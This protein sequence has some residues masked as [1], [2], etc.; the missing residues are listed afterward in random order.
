MKSFWSMTITP[1]RICFFVLCDGINFINSDLWYDFDSGSEGQSLYAAHVMDDVINVYIANS[2][3]SGSSGNSVCGFAYYPWSSSDRI[4]LDKDCASNGST[5][6]HELG[7]YFGLFHTHSQAGQGAE[8]VDGSNCDVAGDYLCDTPADPQLGSGNV[9]SNCIY[10]GNERD[11]NGDLYEPDPKNVMSYSRKSC[12]DYF[13]PEQYARIAYYNEADRNY[14]RCGA[15]L[16]KRFGVF[17]VD[18]STVRATLQ[19][20]ND[21]NLPVEETFYISYF[22]RS[23]DTT[24]LSNDILIGQDT[25]PGLDVSDLI[26]TTFS[27]DVLEVDSCLELGSYH[28]GFIVD[29]INDIEEITEADNEDFSGSPVLE[30]KV[31]SC[32]PADL[33]SI[34]ALDTI[35]AIAGL[36]FSETFNFQNIGQGWADSSDFAVYLS[37]DDELDNDDLSLL[38]SYLEPVESGDTVSYFA[39]V[40][41]PDNAEGIFYLIACANGEMRFGEASLL[42]N[43]AIAVLKVEQPYIDLDLAA[44]DG[45]VTPTF[46]LQMLDLN[47]RLYNQGNVQADS[48]VIRS[49]VMDENSQVYVLLEDLVLDI[50]DSLDFASVFEWPDV[51][52]GDYDMAVCATY[53]GDFNAPSP[54]ICLEYDLELSN[55]FIVTRSVDIDAQSGMFSQSDTLKMDLKVENLGSYQSPSAEMTVMLSTDP[56]PS[57]DDQLLWSDQTTSLLS[58][59]AYDTQLSVPLETIDE[60]S[61]YV[62]SCIDLD[63]IVMETNEMNNCDAWEIT[64]EASTSIDPQIASA[65]EI[66]PNPVKQLL[67]ISIDHPGFSTLNIRS[68]DGRLLHVQQIE[69]EGLYNIDMKSFA[70]GVYS[71]TLY[72]ES[73]TMARRVV[74]N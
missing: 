29:A 35:T 46:P 6:A 67:H 27:I 23:A 41:V 30:L 15:N 40:M 7:H 70:S 44:P 10:T 21:G 18:G 17:T 38:Q 50:A 73:G 43:C 72:H 52:A 42:N 32:Y 53:I 4:V 25:F 26:Q 31:T 39:Q 60:G 11:D 71:V 74:K 19:V 20:S 69:N 28:V 34:D 3:L 58:A 54:T 12:R 63:E 9:N 55:D 33:E 62:L 22:L 14:L 56:I 2:V 51:T 24:A 36:Q 68:L 61:Y 59:E 47:V 49:E 57:G 37:D 16:H 5:F 48:V 66:Y 65:V 64:V 8:L 1:I 45:Q 13:S